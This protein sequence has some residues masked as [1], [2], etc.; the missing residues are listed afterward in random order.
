MGKI[1]NLGKF[2]THFFVLAFVI[3]LRCFGMLIFFYMHNFFPYIIILGKYNTNKVFLSNFQSRV[4]E[5]TYG[6]TTYVFWNWISLR[7]FHADNNN[8]IFLPFLFMW[9]TW[10]G[11]A[12]VS[13]LK[14]L[15]AKVFLP[16]FFKPNFFLLNAYKFFL[17]MKYSL[18]FLFSYYRYRR[19]SCP[20]INLCPQDQGVPHSS[21]TYILVL[22][23]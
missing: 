10:E 20:S 5:S 17:C 2:H 21:I 23:V 22:S 12:N 4:K 1:I 9:L 13:K 16:F 18:T 3:M 14:F 7:I 8:T 15:L 11:E 19:F 6:R